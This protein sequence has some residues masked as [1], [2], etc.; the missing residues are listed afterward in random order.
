[1]SVQQGRKVSGRWRKA[2]RLGS[3]RTRKV[4]V[5]AAVDAHLHDQL[6]EDAVVLGIEASDDAIVRAAVR[7]FHER[8]LDIAADEEIRKFYDG[9]AP[10]PE[11]VAPADAT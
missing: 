5:H 11:G 8:A 6:R 10:L 4:K 3:V 1:M 9:P 7:M 2:G